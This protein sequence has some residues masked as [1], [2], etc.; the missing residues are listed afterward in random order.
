MA[1]AQQSFMVSWDQV[2]GVARTDWFPGAVC[3]L[4]VAVQVTEDVEQLGRGRV[5]SV[6]DLRPLKSIDR[7][8]RQH[9]MNDKSTFRA[10]GLVADAPVSRMI[11]NFFLGMYDQSIPVSMFAAED[12]AIDWLH[13]QP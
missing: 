9:F 5:L 6:V 2:N 1:D 4:P 13:Q 7:P 12:Q 8:S 10:V 11:A 3:T